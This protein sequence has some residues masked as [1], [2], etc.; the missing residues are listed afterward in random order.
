MTHKPS[1]PTVDGLVAH[2]ELENDGADSSG[3][4]LDGTLMGEPNFAEGIIGMA[5]DA[6]GVDD[7][8]DC[9]N[10]VAFDI[11]DQVTVSAWLNIRAINTAWHAAVA[12][13]ENAWRL[14]NVNM[15]PRFHF[16][17]T[18]WN[19]PDTASVDGDSSF[20]LDEWHHV[21]GRFDGRNINVYVDG[22]LD[23]TQ[24]TTVPIGTSTTNMFI[25]DNPESTG[26]YWD[27]L[28]DEVMVFCRALSEPE[29]VNLAREGGG[30]D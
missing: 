13:G 9:S 11:T 10:D 19:A 29:V 24:P 4:G 18:I 26:R 27:G 16:G 12:K 28:I 25:G 14:G 22:E 5:L 17:I 3:N 23:G 6:D 15:D 7:Y 8:I 30:G 21:I 2:Y 20:A 1:D